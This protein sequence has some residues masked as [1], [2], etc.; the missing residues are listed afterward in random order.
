MF[1]KKLL[2]TLIFGLTTHFAWASSDDFC[3]PT[4]AI[5]QGGYS[6]CSNLP[7]LAPSNDTRVNL[8]LLLIDDGYATLQAKPV[9]E[10]AAFGYGKVPFSLETFENDIVM[11]QGKTGDAKKEGESAGYD[12][13]TRCISI[14]SGTADFIAALNQSKDLS[15]TERKMLTK[16][17]QK[18]SPSCVDVPDSKTPN[19]ILNLSSL[20]TKIISSST[21][22]QFMQYLAGATAF[23]EGRYGKAESIF[24]KL[25]NS[26]NPW[27]KEASRYMLGRTEL[28]FAQ[29]GAFDSDGFP[30]LENV[31]KKALLRAEV[32]FKHYLK[33]Y[34]SGRYAPSARGLLRRIYWLS[35]QQEKL[36]AEYEW[37]LTHPDSPQHNLFLSDLAWEADQKLL[38]AA[39]PKQ[40]KNPLLLATLDLSL[41]RPTNSSTKQISYSDLQKQQPLF[42][43]HKALYE[44]LLAA[45]RFYVQKDAANTL[46]ALSDTIPEKVT[47]LDFSKLSLRGLALEETKDHSGARK[48]WLSLLPIFRQPLQNETLQ[49]AL[50]L[51]YE[52]SNEPELAFKANSP[53][54]ETQIRTILLRND[55][56]AELLRQVIK[57]KNNS[58][59]ERDTALYTLL[60]K[61]LLQGHYQNYIQDYLFLPKDASKHT[62]SPNMDNADKPFLALFTWSGKNSDDGYNCPSTLGIAK[63]LA[64]NAEDPYGLICLGDFIN[65]NDLPSGYVSSAHSAQQSLDV[66]TAVL[67]SAP[68]HFPGDQFSRGEAY[69]TIITDV[70]AAPDLKAYALY[71]A[72]KCYETSGNNHCGGEDVEKSVRKSWFQT[73]KKRYT[74]T[75]WAK[76]LK[77]YW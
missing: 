65:S 48:L 77:Y 12:G 72:T 5:N 31:D 23:Y 63:I 60:Y 28:N 43:G 13:G 1:S 61:D 19:K 74:N 49:L 21:C 26:K 64:K 34:P 44:Y 2:L 40:I 3:E 73:L 58:S 29:Q 75:D 30:T 11:P 42:A 33:E 36:A 22:K 67:G 50:A 66:S 54:T 18:L 71:R 16:E 52:H 32:K 46:K 53:I 35:N 20:K 6:H 38:F 4:W 27:L 8:I 47:Y 39:D 9:K 56:S 15:A 17:R 68:S 76:K 41:M 62:R 69:K 14:D 57:S 37:Q 10:D 59:Q 24:A 7:F 55:A 51:N 70:K 25:I 45:H